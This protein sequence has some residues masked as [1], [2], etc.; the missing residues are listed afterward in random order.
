MKAVPAIAVSLA[1]AMLASC[2][3][4]TSHVEAAYTPTALYEN[5]TCEQLLREGWAVSNRAHS[6]IGKQNRHRVEDDVAVT[7][8]LLV[9]W[10]ALFF[11]HG[12]D[13]TTAELAQLKGEME[14]IERAS[15]EK[16]CGIVFNRV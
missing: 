12:N 5:L 1:A 11:V 7:A 10:P 14:A 13:A 9:F 8:G 2:A 6:A 15:E 16:R 4:K 3:Q